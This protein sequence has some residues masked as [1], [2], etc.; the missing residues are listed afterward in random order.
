MGTVSPHQTSFLWC[1][2][3]RGKHISSIRDVFLSLILHHLWP[4]LPLARHTGLSHLLWH[5]QVGRVRTHRQTAH[6]ALLEGPLEGPWVS[7]P[8]QQLCGSIVKVGRVL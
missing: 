3:V 6:Q 4:S 8:V 5:V 7:T 2:Y 1:L